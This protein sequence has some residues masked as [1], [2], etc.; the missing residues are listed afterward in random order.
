MARLRRLWA[1][2]VDAAEFCWG[3]AGIL[4]K[5]VLCAL[6]GAVGGLLARWVFGL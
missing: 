6:F 5:I 2:Y 4:A 3:G 1:D